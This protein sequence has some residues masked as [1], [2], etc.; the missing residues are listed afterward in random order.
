VGAEQSS[1]CVW[2]SEHDREVATLSLAKPVRGLEFSPCRPHLALLHVD[3]ALSVFDSET[4][5]LVWSLQQNSPKRRSGV[6]TYSVEGDQLAIASENELVVRNAMTG[7]ELSGYALNGGPLRAGDVACLAFDASGERIAAGDSL[8]NVAV[9]DWAGKRLINHFRAHDGAC[10][11][12][13]FGTGD[14]LASSGSDLSLGLWD[15]TSGVQQARLLGHRSP[16]RQIGFSDAGGTLRTLTPYEVKYWS[17]SPEPEPITTV[18]AQETGGRGDARVVG[19]AR[20]GYWLYEPHNGSCSLR[21]MAT[22]EATATYRIPADVVGYAVPRLVHENGTMFAWTAHT[23]E[24]LAIDLSTGRTLARTPQWPPATRLTASKDA[25]YVAWR[26]AFSD[27]ELWQP[28]T[29]KRSVV[30]GTAGGGE[31]VF[32]ADGTR[33]ATVVDN[34]GLRETVRVWDCATRGPIVDLEAA[35]LRLTCLAFDPSGATLAAG[36]SNGEV[37]VW[38]IASGALTGEW[39]ADTPGI[40]CLAF[41][42]DDARLFTAGQDG[43]IRLWDTQSH[44]ELLVLDEF[45][46]RARALVFAE[47]VLTAISESHVCTWRDTALAPAQLAR[48]RAVRAARSVVAELAIKIVTRAAMLEH[49]DNQEDLDSDVR[50]IA[51]TI[52]SNLPDQ[53]SKPHRLPGSSP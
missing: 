25:E 23:R 51:R 41:G 47:E 16:I 1:V 3:G 33:L 13:R 38:A 37:R 27:V 35:G 43:T 26:D 17:A 9:V 14:T 11:S 28:G 46:G 10:T 36:N 32:S 48:R 5:T 12:I 7:Q 45:P 30:P 19:L 34:A 24:L 20:S 42:E 21:D 4:G 6:L 39:Q 8:G 29:G 15:G 2:D 40:D 44:D 52:I 22:D 49:V 50:E 18:F 53:R 31:P